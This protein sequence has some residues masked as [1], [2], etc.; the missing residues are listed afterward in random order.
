[1]L[2]RRMHFAIE[3]LDYDESYSLTGEVENEA[4]DD[5]DDSFNLVPLFCKSTLVPTYPGFVRTVLQ[6]GYAFQ[7]SS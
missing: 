2:E 7:A 5:D 1:M 3:S 4:D 6:Y